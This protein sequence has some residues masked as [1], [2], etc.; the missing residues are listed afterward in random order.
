MILPFLFSSCAVHENSRIEDYADSATKLKLMT[1][2]EIEATEWHYY[3]LN[4]QLLQMRDH[5]KQGNDI[6]R[7][8]QQLIDSGLL[9]PPILYT[10]VDSGFEAN[11]VD[12]ATYRSYRL[13]NEI[14]TNRNG[15]ILLKIEGPFLDSLRSY[16][17]NFDSAIEDLRKK[18]SSA[19]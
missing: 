9:A 1:V 8:M 7:R 6:V 3:S 13:Q 14:D 16:R 5:L 19:Q 10:Q 17:D 4:E 2:G 12:Y 11:A 15:P 18:L